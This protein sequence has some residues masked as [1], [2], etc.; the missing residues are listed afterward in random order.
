M[1]SILEEGVFIQD[2]GMN[3]LEVK[4]MG[5]WSAVYEEDAICELGSSLLILPTNTY[6][7]LHYF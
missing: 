7:I 6:N 4:V 2:S 3:S 5:F 1:F